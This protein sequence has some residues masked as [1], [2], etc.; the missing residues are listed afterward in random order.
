MQLSNTGDLSDTSATATT[1]IAEGAE[2]SHGEGVGSLQ[3]CS[4]VTNAKL[5]ILGDKYDIPK[6]KREA[7]R[8][9]TELVMKLWN[10]S[11]FVD[12]ARLIYDNIIDQQDILRDV[13]INATHNPLIRGDYF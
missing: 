3:S 10:S 9:H 13:I 1:I 4:L 7:A 2:H 11:A 12:S 6:L 5:C 8:K